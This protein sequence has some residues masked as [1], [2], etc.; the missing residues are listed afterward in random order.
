MSDAILILNAGSSSIKFSLFEGHVRPGAKGLIC[1]GELDGIGHRV[2]FVAKDNSGATLAD[3]YLTDAAT[4]ENTLA[5]LLRWVE[6]QFSNSDLV[7][8]GHRVV[9]G[10]S[11]Y[12]SPV[13]I[14]PT[15]IGELNKLIPLAPLHQPHNLAAIAA[16]SKLHPALPQVACFDTAF[17]HTQPEIATAFALPRAITDQGIRRYGFHGLSYEYIASILPDV[18]GPAAAEGRV[19]VAHLG[20]G[21]S[22]CAMHRRQSVATT[23]GFTALDGLPM[24]TRCGNLDPGVVLYLLR[25]KGMTPQAVTDLLYHSSGLLG[26]SG[27]SDDMRALLASDDPLAARAIA[28]FVYRI[29]R[30]LGS[31]AASLGGLDALVFTAGIGEHAPEIR[32]QA[33]QQAAWLG[34]ELDEAAN[35]AGASRITTPDSR[36]SAW[37]IPTNEDLMIARHTWRLTDDG[38]TEKN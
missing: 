17:H 13:R 20:N 12:S 11:V 15:V 3:Q 4:H 14:D 23:M 24:G 1:D 7:A 21:A 19:V 28:L 6:R 31:L 8:A 27:V 2:H 37:V 38:A 9:H 33:C 10:G 30:E 5:A 25:E 26:V 18:L 29:S 35:T 32:R 36:T 22:M 16:I 34:I